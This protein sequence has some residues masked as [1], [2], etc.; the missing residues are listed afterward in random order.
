MQLIKFKKMKQIFLIL[1]FTVTLNCKSQTIVALYN[2]TD[3]IVNNPYYKDVDNDFNPFIGEWKWENGTDSWTIQLQKMTMVPRGNSFYDEIFGE[4]KYIENGQVLVNTLPLVANTSDLTT[5]NIWGGVIT[6]L[7]RGFPPCSE[8]Q[9]DT[10]FII[11]YLKDSTRPGLH[12]EIIMA[13]FTEGGI[14]KIRMRV[15][16]TFNE[17]ATADYT[18]PNELTIPEG[19]Y[20]FVKQD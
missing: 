1:L 11:L 13:H 8:C 9:P 20:T 19:V 5:H 16:N 18:G 3:D 17:N 14:E 6:T 7:N 2:G 4:Y 15:L 10:R 12:G